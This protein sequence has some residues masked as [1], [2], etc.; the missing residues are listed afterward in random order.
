MKSLNYYQ[1]L[2][3]DI[4]IEKETLDGETWYISYCRELGRF[5]CYGT[6]ETQQEAVTYFLEDKKEFIELLYNKG[7]NIPEPYKKQKSE[8]LLSGA[9]MVRTSPQLHTKLMETAKEHHISLNKYVNQLFIEAMTRKHIES[10]L[11][12]SMNKKFDEIKQKLD[13]HRDF[14]S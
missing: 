7:E 10:K 6:G 9:F 4:I 2:D 8:H 12:E 13:L 11:Y 14:I 1:N 5:S 3:Y